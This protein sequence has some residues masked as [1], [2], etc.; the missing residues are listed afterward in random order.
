MAKVELQEVT[1]IPLP[2]SKASQGTTWQEVQ[3][4]PDTVKITIRGVS[5]MLFS[6]VSGI[7]GATEPADGGASGSTTHTFIANA[8]APL[9]IKLRDR[10]YPISDGTYA[11]SIFVAAVTGTS[12]FSLLF[13]MAG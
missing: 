7:S 6:F 2:Y 11:T 10:Q 8:T 9:E 12:N 5:D 3:F 1:N 4:P 13:E